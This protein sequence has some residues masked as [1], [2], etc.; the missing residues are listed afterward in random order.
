MKNKLA[1]LPEVPANE[2]QLFPICSRL[3]KPEVEVVGDSDAALTADFME[4]Q[5]ACSFL[6]ELLQH[7]PATALYDEC[8]PM[9][10]NVS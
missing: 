6:A 10:L 3:P 4:A 2:T 5:F 1:I 9:K 8:G 7:A